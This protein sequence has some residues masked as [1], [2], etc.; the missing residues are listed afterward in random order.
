M[1]RWERWFMHSGVFFGAFGVN[2]TYLRL[3]W[4]FFVSN[5]AIV[6]SGR[7]LPSGRRNRSHFGSF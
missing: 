5:E 2:D 6:L 1:I 4:I 3:A 7:F